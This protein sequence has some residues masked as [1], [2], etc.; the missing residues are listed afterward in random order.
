MM[1]PDCLKN[2]TLPDVAKSAKLRLLILDYTTKH[3]SET[4]APKGS[5][6]KSYASESQKKL[7]EEQSAR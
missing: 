5:F 6:K 1:G 2:V 3:W 4:D 7:D